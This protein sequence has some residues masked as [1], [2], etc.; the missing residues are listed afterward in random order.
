MNYRN[1]IVMKD[2]KDRIKIIAAA[3]VTALLVA[4]DQYTK[5]LA[6]NGLKN[7]PSFKIIDGV[8]E[9]T[10][11]QNRGAAWGMLEGKQGFFA[12]LTVIV[13][14]ALV[15]VIIRTPSTRRYMPVN[16]SAVLLAS[17]ALGNFIDRCIYGYVRDFIYFR[18]IDFPVFNVADV[19]VTLATAVFVIVFL[20]VYKDGDFAYLIPKRQKR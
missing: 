6:A 1:G 2:R 16:I 11:L 15:Y 14:T 8:L 17:G 18:I 7:K 10:Y 5:Y 13:L 12:V 9:L 4:A 3:A 19:Y 20:F